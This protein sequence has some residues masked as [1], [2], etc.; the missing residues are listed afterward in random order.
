MQFQSAGSVSDEQ[1]RV[2]AT[3]V[4]LEIPSRDEHWADK[5]DGPVTHLALH[6][7]TIS[8][9]DFMLCFTI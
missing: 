9:T 4:L 5:E 7:A 2:T 1:A 6:T 3:P 8:M